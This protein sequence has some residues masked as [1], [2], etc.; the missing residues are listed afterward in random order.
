MGL[1]VRFF[2]LEY[3]FSHILDWIP[4]LLQKI[5]Y[6]LSFFGGLSWFATIICAFCF[7]GIIILVIKISRVQGKIIIRLEEPPLKEVIPEERKNKWDEIQK[8]AASDN[9]QEWQEAIIESENII[10]D[11]LRKIGYGGENLEEMLK[12]IEPSDFENIQK[13]WEAHQVRKKIEV[14]GER[15]VLTKELVKETI[16]KYKAALKEFKYI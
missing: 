14:E 15:F 4:Y 7:A 9:P 5:L 3:I 16:D 8:K 2:N 10:N 12:V 11:I 1:E 13:V 6:L